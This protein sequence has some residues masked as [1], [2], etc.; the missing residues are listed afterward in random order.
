MSARKP[1]AFLCALGL[2]ACAAPPGPAGAAA[3]APPPLDG[4]RWLG[5]AEGSLESM[6]P[7]LEFGGGGRLTGFTG[8][9][10]L[11][12]TWR[13]EGGEVRFGPIATTKRACLGAAGEIE[14]R[15]NAAMGE[16]TK[17][18]REGDKL[19]I[20]GVGGARFEFVRAAGN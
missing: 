14:G 17:V 13:M 8:C 9:N 15:F 20:T 2:V 4:T 1:F 10:P 19:V 11:T 5:V 18:R 16:G 6:R 12:G 7:R 3:S